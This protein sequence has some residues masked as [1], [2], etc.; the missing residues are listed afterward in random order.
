MI[1][2]AAR[3]A[4]VRERIER[5][6]VAAGRPRGCVRL[7]AVSKTHP[8]EAVRAAV[9]A[10]QQAFG[11]NRVQ[12]LLAKAS[13]VDAEW[14]LVGQLQRNKVNEVVGHAA[15][16]HSVDRPEL[17]ER[18]GRRAVALGRVQ[19]VLL[20]V[21][22]ADD[23]AKAGCR[24]S[25]LP[26]LVTYAA[27]IEGL[28]VEGLMTVPPLPPEGQDHEQ[29]A[30]PAFRRLR[31]ALEALRVRHPGLCELSMGMSDDLEIAVREGATMVRIGSAVFGARPEVAR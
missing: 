11:E 12:E 5:A 21:N 19:A 1:D 10:G 27:S 3:L 29:T 6:E 18:I 22:V 31:E 30:G 25:D 23:P 2:I 28:Q 26:G 15:L 9:A 24:L 8:V 14:H 17:A 13:E 16:I 7:I 4:N 20:Q